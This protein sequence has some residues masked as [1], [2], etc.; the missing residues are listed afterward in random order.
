MLLL[1]LLRVCSELFLSF[2]SASCRNM[3]Q[4]L[5]E[6]ARE[7]A[8]GIPGVCDLTFGRSF[9][10]AR[11]CGY[12]HCLNVRFESKEAGDLYQ[13]HV[14]HSAFKKHLLINMLIFIIF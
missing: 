10:T 7:M 6:A 8:E 14:L 12:T 11:S 9:T 2:S 1:L 4:R 13:P 3:D 5:H